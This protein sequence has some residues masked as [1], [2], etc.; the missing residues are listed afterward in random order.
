MPDQI[1]YVILMLGSKPAYDIC[2]LSI[3]QIQW[4]V[5]YLLVIFHLNNAFIQEAMRSEEFSEKS[6]FDFENYVSL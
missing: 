2:L 5:I 4:I 3:T 6:E 1:E